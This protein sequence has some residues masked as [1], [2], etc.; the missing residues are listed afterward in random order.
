MI[1]SAFFDC[2]LSLVSDLASLHDQTHCGYMGKKNVKKTAVHVS[3][4][5]LSAESYFNNSMFT[6]FTYMV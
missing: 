2:V 3:L 5:G 1:D 6:V 4:H